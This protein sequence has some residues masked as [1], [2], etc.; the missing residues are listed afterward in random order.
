MEEKGCQIR[1]LHIIQQ[2]LAIELVYNEILPLLLSAN[3]HAADGQMCM[4]HERDSVL[5]HGNT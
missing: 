3:Y 1:H 2:G 4:N 5:G